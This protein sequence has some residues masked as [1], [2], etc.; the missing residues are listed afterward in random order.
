M[1]IQFQFS[2]W[3]LNQESPKYEAGEHTTRL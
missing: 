1:D 3:E 2:N